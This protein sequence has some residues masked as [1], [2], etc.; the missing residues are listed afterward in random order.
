MSAVTAALAAGL[1]LQGCGGTSTASPGD[2]RG[3][4]AGTGGMASGGKTTTGGTTANAGTA[5]AGET[6]GGTTNGGAT[7]GGSTTGGSTTGGAPNFPCKNPMPVL[8]A[9]GKPTGLETCETGG[10]HRTEP[11]ECA[12]KLPRAEACQALGSSPSTCAKDGDCTA[13]QYGTCSVIGQAGSCECSYGCSTD[14]DCGNGGVCVCG[15]IVGYCESATCRSDDDCAPGY[16]CRTF[17]DPT[18]S[19]CNI[20]RFE[21]QTPS[22][23]CEGNANCT[24]GQ[25]CVADAKGEHH[26]KA[27]SCGVPGRPFLIDGCAVTANVLERRDWLDDCAPTAD[28]S[29]L[30]PAA[31]EA[32]TAHYT[33]AAQL[34]HASIAAFARFTLQLLELGA[35]AELVAGSQRALADE[36]E[37]AKAC[38]GLASRFAGQALGPAGLPIAGCLGET[39]LADVLRLAVREGCIGETVAAVQASEAYAHATDADVRRALFDIQRDEARHAELAFRFV[40]WALERDAQ[41]RAIVLD[42][43]ESAQRRAARLQVGDASSDLQCVAHGL[44]P[45]THLVDLERRVVDDVVALLLR[46]LVTETTARAA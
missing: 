14:A 37:H 13:K 23:T 21:C 16:Q 17:Q 40:R 9:N 2:D 32:L 31:R 30:T 15:G 41:L 4:A 43:L 1:G 46:E 34:E 18:S 19:I 8:D 29:K 20:S 36:L 27:F 33:R 44:L 26:C 28:D 11:T 22:D 25:Y 24:A 38:F 35:P 6:T 42:E 7:T 10:N 39:T 5:T 3:G 12:V 45:A